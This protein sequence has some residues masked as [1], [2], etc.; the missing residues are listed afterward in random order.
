MIESGYFGITIQKDENYKQSFELS[1]DDIKK[2]PIVLCEIQSKFTVKNNS[3]RDSILLR[4]YPFKDIKN[5]TE[6]YYSGRKSLKFYEF[7]KL[8]DDNKVRLN[9]NELANILLSMNKEP[10]LKDSVMEI[11]RYARFTTGYKRDGERYYRMQLFLSYDCVVSIFLNRITL[12]TISRL[13]QSKYLSPI[14]FI[15]PT[16][17]DV[18]FS[19]ENND[20]I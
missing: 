4:V 2:F 16:N 12:D 6:M 14:T 15:E 19:N 18:E 13:I 9:R 10:E 5:P 1:K 8:N 17:D 3:R 11:L 7:L 20:L